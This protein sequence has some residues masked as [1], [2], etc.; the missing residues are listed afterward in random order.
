VSI[1]LLPPPC[2]S[3]LAHALRPCGPSDSELGPW[4]VGGKLD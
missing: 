2:Y 1:L 4:L 3:S